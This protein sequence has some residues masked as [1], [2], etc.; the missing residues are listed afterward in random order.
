MTYRNKEFSMRSFCLVVSISFAVI[1]C[2]RTSDTV[3]VASSVDAQAS[4]AR[5]ADAPDAKARAPITATWVEESFTKAGVTLVA[6]IERRAF[7][8]MP[9]TVDVL[10]PKG[11][12]VDGERSFVIP[13][14]D[15]PDVT[16]RR[17]LIRYDAVPSGDVVLSVDGRTEGFGFHAEVPWTIGAEA[18]AQPRPVADGP[19]IKAGGIDFGRAVQVTPSKKTP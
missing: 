17:Y 18:K 3:K 1:G 19:A 2:T 15:K 8:Q 5:F 14:S 13:A 10:A 16:E 7:T 11:A 6:R 9:L 12:E 4:V